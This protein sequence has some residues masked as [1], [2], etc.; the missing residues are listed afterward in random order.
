MPQSSTAIATAATVSGPVRAEGIGPGGGERER[1]R[2]NAIDAART[3][4]I[5]GMFVNHVAGSAAD[6]WTF[7]R[8]VDG[9]SAGG[10]VVLA[11]V[12]MGLTRRL[13]VRGWRAWP[14]Q[15][16]RSALLFA[17]GVALARISFGPVVILAV[18]ALVFLAA[19]PFRRLSGPALVVVGLV[20]TVAWPAVS[21]WLR[22]QVLDGSAVDAGHHVTWSMLTGPRPVAISARTLFLD[23]TYP[24]PTW[25]SLALVAW[26]AQRCGLVRRE[27]LGRLAAASAL[28]LAA[29]FGG[30][31]GVEAATGAR[32]EL[33]D[34]LTAD[35]AA[36][37]QPVSVP[38]FDNGTGVPVSGDAQVLLTAGHHTGTTFELWQILGVT[39]AALA[40]WA[41]VERWGSRALVR[42]AALPGRIPLTVYSAHLLA[43]W[44]MAKWDVGFGLSAGPQGLV[45]VAFVAGAFVVGWLFRGRRGPLEWVLHRAAQA[46]TPSIK[47]LRCRFPQG[48]VPSR[49]RPSSPPSSARWR[50]PT[51]S[52][53]RSIH[54]PL[55]DGHSVLS[56]AVPPGGTASPGRRAPGCGS[57][58]PPG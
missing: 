36:G 25:L 19:L 11:G 18:Y 47:A 31:A 30:A 46:V 34:R 9:Y 22:T 35:A 2:L 41:T 48:N 14:P 53:L 56:P 21:L 17:L 16:A 44:A 57:A 24:V 43:G 38:S 15:L 10:F 12:S 58:A 50:R 20:L 45:L 13:S 26:G 5:L 52:H 49:P 33:I 51:G 29:G 1:R 27:A 54:P 7:L 42:A 37:G 40:G 32:A 6:R 39:G 4:A 8:W 3:L 55:P 23:G 28:M